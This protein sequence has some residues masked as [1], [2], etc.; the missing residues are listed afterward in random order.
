VY[1]TYV[2]TGGTVN[3]PAD[4]VNAYQRK[5]WTDPPR[6]SGDITRT[7]VEGRPL[8]YPPEMREARCSSGGRVE[9][10]YRA[11]RGD[12]VDRGELGIGSPEALRRW[13]AAQRSMMDRGRAHDG[14]DRSDPRAEAAGRRVVSS[15]R[16]PQ[17]RI[18]FSGSLPLRWS[19][20]R[21]SG[22]AVGALAVRG[23]EHPWA[24][25]GRKLR[26]TSS[27]TWSSTA[28]APRFIPLLTERSTQ[29]SP[30]RSPSMAANSLDTV[31]VFRDS[32]VSRII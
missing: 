1:R 8:K 29:P 27:A 14:G 15:E 17:D 18:G 31:A 6:V 16:D 26:S 30:S 20:V 10:E 21:G 11:R 28:V 4:K 9:R 23:E 2:R 32:S 5:L 19:R 3:L 13:S 25:V 7:E 22:S 12:P 24:V